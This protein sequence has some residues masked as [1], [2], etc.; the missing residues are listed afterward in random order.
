[1]DSSFRNCI[2]LLITHLAIGLL[3]YSNRH[4]FESLLYQV[5]I[6]KLEDNESTSSNITATLPYEEQI[7]TAE[8]NVNSPLY[9]IQLAKFESFIFTLLTDFEADAAHELHPILLEKIQM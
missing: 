8:S 6:E 3:G 1:M 7:P 5:E 4:L 9:L 2:F